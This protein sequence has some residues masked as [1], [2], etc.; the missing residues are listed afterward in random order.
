MK[1]LVLNFGTPSTAFFF[2]LIK[3]IFLQTLIEIIFR[4]H[5]FFLLQ[6]WDPPMNIMSF[7]HMRCWVS[8]YGKKICLKFF[9]KVHIIR[10]FRAY[11]PEWKCDKNVYIFVYVYICI[12]INIYIYRRANGIYISKK[13]EAYGQ[14]VLVFIKAKKTILYWV[15]QILRPKSSSLNIFQKFLQKWT[16]HTLFTLFWYP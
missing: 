10:L 11:H 8:K 6:F 7:F 3:K 16:Q 2:A 1:A 15:S 5:S 4:Y 13:V 12:Y 9:Q 14:F